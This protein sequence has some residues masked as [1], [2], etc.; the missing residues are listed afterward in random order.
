MSG[1]IRYCENCH[2]STKHCLH[3]ECTEC[4]VGYEKCI[5][6]TLRGSGMKTVYE[7]NKA[8]CE[9]LNISEIGFRNQDNKKT[10][11]SS[12]FVG[13]STH[14]GFGPKTCAERGIYME[15][16]ILPDLRVYINDCDDGRIEAQ[17][18]THKEAD[19]LVKLIHRYA[20]IS[21]WELTE[22]LDFEWVS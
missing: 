19:D 4:H 10:Y 14:G 15:M 3:E 2:K 12:Y 13:H 20:P 8:F 22:F 17:C 16:S 11:A 7:T 1:M 5:K 9:A 18:K 21:M 6:A